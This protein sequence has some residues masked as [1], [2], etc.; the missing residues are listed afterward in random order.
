MKLEKLN[1]IT[2][3]ASQ[4]SDTEIDEKKRPREAGL[5]QL[6]ESVNLVQAFRSPEHESVR[7][8][9][10]EAIRESSKD[11]LPACQEATVLVADCIHVVNSAR[12][13]GRPSKE[14]LNELSERS[15]GALEALRTLRT[16]FTKDATEL[17][18]QAHADIFDEKGILKSVDQASIYSL[19]GIT[20]AMT[21]EE[22][23]L[24]AA[25]A[26]E[27][28]LAQVAALL[29]ERQTVRLWLPRG[30]RYA[31]DWV[32]RRSAVAPVI[33][34]D[35]STVDPD[36]AGAQSKAAQQRLRISRGYR[37]KRRSGLG[38][39]ILSTYHW[40]IN[41]EGMYALR[42]VI[43]TVAL[44]I[45]AVLP[46]SAGFYY[47][48]KGLWGLIMSQTGLLVY[49]ADFILSGIARFVGTILGGV[50]GL[51]AWYIGSGYGPGNP[52]GLAA[53]MAVATVILMWGRLFA[54]PAFLQATIMGGAT[55]ILVVGYSYDDT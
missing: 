17:L 11:I 36:V 48:E 33:A 34:G 37:V 19:R 54:P 44:A 18:I 12:W 23:I 10:L 26:W 53:I 28:V 38:R 1:E 15:Q 51:V 6:M 45:P 5:R 27:K 3:G 4:D 43:V 31:V 46:S 2:A 52:Y 9:T 14:R 22:Q 25:D 20:L 29:H 40:L 21:F 24:S 8:E 49:M 32:F 50:L 35:A 13:F 30:L 42:M 47:R 41:A 16:S 39:A 7:T 55:F